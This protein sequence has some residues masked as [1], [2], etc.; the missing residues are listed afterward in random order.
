MEYNKISESEMNVLNKL[1]NFG[2]MIT[3]AEMVSSLNKDGKNWAY[4][5]VATFLKRLETKGIVSS[6]K[7]CKRL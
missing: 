6:S 1:W 5:T 3:V 2:E 7:K 4:Q